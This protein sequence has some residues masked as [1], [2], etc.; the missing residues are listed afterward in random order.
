MRA[1][2]RIGEASFKS[3]A[4]N[5]GVTRLPLNFPGVGQFP[6]KSG[7]TR[8][9]LSVGEECLLL[10]VRNIPDA[11]FA[12]LQRGHGSGTRRNLVHGFGFAPRGKTMR[13]CGL[14]GDRG[15]GRALL[16]V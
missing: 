7:S 9:Q 2:S 3:E 16:M 10:V 4:T 11:G 5:Q 6:L 15:V 8:V 1:N 13:R 12:N 14:H